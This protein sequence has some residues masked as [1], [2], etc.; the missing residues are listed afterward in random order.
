MLGIT[1]LKVAVGGGGKSGKGGQNRGGTAASIMDYVEDRQAADYY[2]EDGKAE[3]VA[4]GKLWSALGL[5]D[6]EQPTREQMMNLLNGKGLSG[7]KTAEIRA[8][9]EHIHKSGPKK[10]EKLTKEELNKAPGYQVAG[11]DMT[12]S[13]PK[14]VSAIYAMAVMNDDKETA[15]AIKK[16]FRDSIEA[17]VASVEQQGVFKVRDGLNG[18]QISDANALAVLTSYH[19]TSRAEDPQLHGHSIVANLAMSGDAWRRLEGKGAFHHKMELGAVQRAELAQNLIKM[20]FSIERD[21]KSF[22]VVGTPAKLEKE[23]SKGGAKIKEQLVEWGV[24]GGKAAQSAALKVRDDKKH[25]TKAVLHEKWNTEAEKLGITYEQLEAIRS[26]AP[27]SVAYN[28]GEVIAGLTEKHATF[29]DLDLR[30]EIAIAMNAGGGGISEIYAAVESIKK[31]PEMVELVDQDGSVRWTTAEMRETEMEMVATVNRRSGKAKPVSDEI[32]TA[33][34]QESEAEF[35]KQFKD[36]SWRFSP[37]QANMIR[38][39]CQS[40]DLDVMCSGVAGAG[41]STMARAL[42]IAFDKAGLDIYG[43]AMASKAASGLGDSTGIEKIS[44]ID[45][46]LLAVEKGKIIPKAGSL[47][48]IDEANMSSTRQIAKLIQVADRYDLKLPLIGDPKQLQ[49]IMAG[50]AYKFL[51]DNAKSM[52]RETAT[53]ETSVRTRGEKKEEFRAAI[54]AIRDGNSRPVLEMLDKLGNLKIAEE[55]DYIK[56][57][58][59]AFMHNQ[60]AGLKDKDNVFV[61][62]RKDVRDQLNEAARIANGQ[63]ARTDNVE[64]QVTNKDGTPAGTLNFAP[65]DRIISLQNDRQ[66]KME[67]GRCWTVNEVMKSEKTGDVF[68]KL[69]DDE[70]R[71]REITTAEYSRFTH[72]YALTV[73][74]AEGISAEGPICVPTD[75][76]MSD[77]HAFYVMVSRAKQAVYSHIII[78]ENLIDEMEEVNSVEASAATQNPVDR[79]VGFMK[80]VARERYDHLSLTYQLKK[81]YDAQQKGLPQVEKKE[82]VKPWMTMPTSTT[83]TANMTDAQLSSAKNSFD[84]WATMNPG[85]AEKYGFEGYVGYVQEQFAKKTEAETLRKGQTIGEATKPAPIVPPTTI[86]PKHETVAEAKKEQKAEEKKEAA[87]IKPPEPEPTQE[88]ATQTPVRKGIARRR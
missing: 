54:H 64:V 1:K 34:I 74:A 57:A 29:S 72:A 25:S 31:N 79:M 59:A 66:L 82:A 32:T 19:E 23:W 46:F 68:L 15:A 11:Y 28:E 7:E 20:G 77:M 44:T 36:P 86:S 30:R 50:S 84:K 35:Q 9:K 55:G 16:A 65:G 88:E 45:S 62:N 41:K 27:K 47:L 17:T 48:L 81:D 12:W 80:A 76:S 83:P 24:T 43:M 13:A 61:T 18:T 10:G 26:I 73:H 21:G 6:G 40:E 85:L 53:I 8:I 38:L 78:P 3:Q 69:T 33:A 75:A 42:K 39:I 71:I 63:A 14:S 49:A 67:N 70:G 51:L 60:A 37:E 58:V 4:H 22:R 5:A 56:E 87:K 2:G 52:K